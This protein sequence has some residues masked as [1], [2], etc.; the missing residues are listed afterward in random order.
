M[1][2]LFDPEILAD[3]VRMHLALPIDRQVAAV[4]Q[5]L[6]EVYGAHVNPRQ[7]W[8]WSTAGGIMCAISPLHVSLNEYL[9]FCGTAIGSQGHSGRHRAEIFDVVMAGEL[10]TY[11]VGMFD[12]VLHRPGD[13]ARLSRGRA[14]GSKL[15]A[16]AWMLEYARGNVISLLPFALGDTLFSTLDLTDFRQ[17]LGVTGRLMMREGLVRL[18][19]R[20][21]GRRFSPNLDCLKRSASYSAEPGSGGDLR[22]N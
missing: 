3:I 18:E 1:A 7:P 12:P 15:G 13:L 8:M 16:G 11:E 5:S 20:V 17:Q 2:Y 19:E 22:W 10:Q 9:L 6:V 21:S 14:N 4:S